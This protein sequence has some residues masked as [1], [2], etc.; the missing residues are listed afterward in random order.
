M[1][2][3]NLIVDLS[4]H[5]GDVEFPR[6]KAAGVVGVIH[7]ATQG[8]KFVDPTYAKNRKAA[9]DIGLLWGAYHFSTGGDGLLKPNTFSRWSG[10]RKMF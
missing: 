7:K 5:N 10:V 1:I 2:G 9:T 3:S 6:A 8:T 4:H